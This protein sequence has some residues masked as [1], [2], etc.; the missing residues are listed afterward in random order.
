MVHLTGHRLARQQVAEAIVETV[1]GLGG[2]MT[3]DDLARHEST[4]EPPISTR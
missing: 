2:V 3:L 4:F 1:R